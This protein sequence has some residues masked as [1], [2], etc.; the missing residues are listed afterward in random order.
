MSRQSKNL[1]AFLYNNPNA[2][3]EQAWAAAWE[4]AQKVY[5]SKTMNEYKDRIAILEAQLTAE[6]ERV[7]VLEDAL[8]SLLSTAE[9][10][11][12]WESFPSDA[13]DA[14]HSAL[15]ATAQEVSNERPADKV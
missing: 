1:R 15:Q 7:R 10:C 4:G 2:T 9:R 12:G 13:L 5:H 6:R 8:G 11:D 3:I 14:G